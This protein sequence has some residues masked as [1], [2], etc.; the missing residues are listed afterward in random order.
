MGC[1]VALV[2]A[3]NQL[4]ACLAPPL[5]EEE[6]VSA[7]AGAISVDLHIGCAAV[8][9]AGSIVLNLEERARALCALSSALTLAT[10]FEILPTLSA[11]LPVLIVSVFTFR[12]SLAL[13]TGSFH[14]ARQL[15][16]RQTGAPPFVSI[17]AVFTLGALVLRARHTPRELEAAGRA[18]CNREKRRFTALHSEVIDSQGRVAGQGRVTFDYSSLG[19]AS[20]LSRQCLCLDKKAWDAP[21][22]EILGGTL[23]AVFSQMILTVAALVVVV[24][25]EPRFTLLLCENKKAS[26]RC[27]DQ[28]KAGQRAYLAK[29][30]DSTPSADFNSPFKILSLAHL[31]AEIEYFNKNLEDVHSGDN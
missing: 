26:G 1:L 12:A 15:T 22:A 27:S 17:V 8:A 29:L 3:R 30:L 16:T 31:V 28:E 2:A 20:L 13:R 11:P 18:L 5:G 6:S 24:G 10:A 25:E 7:G 23:D 19:D 4:V 21:V 9:F 14:T